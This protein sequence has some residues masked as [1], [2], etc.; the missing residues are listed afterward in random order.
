M[1]RPRLVTVGEAMIRLSPP[2]GLRVRDS[3]SFDVHVGGA[4]INVAVAAAQLGVDAVWVSALPK[5]PL[6]ERIVDHARRFRV[7]PIIC[8]SD[9]RVGVYFVELGA[10]PRG[11]EVHYD[12]QN[13]AFCVSPT[14]HAVAEQVAKPVDAVLVSGISVALGELPQRSVNVLLDRSHGAVRY[15]EIN[16][17]AKLWSES[18]AREAIAE[19]LDH[20]DVLIASKYDLTGLLALDPDPV[21]A[22]QRARE[23][24]RIDRVVITER[25]GGVGERGTN[26]VIVVDDD[27][28][29]VAQAEGMVI[30]PVGAGDAAT[31]A[32]IGTLLTT[33][34]VQ[35]AAE[36]SVRA[37]AMKQTVRGDAVALEVASIR[38][39]G[40]RI[41]R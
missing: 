9:A 11:S 40:P 8:P 2:S 36:A 29:A 7:E 13:S 41:R 14:E 16:H 23:R 37:A 38:G 26:A 35:Q 20:V 6:A 5:S 3:V 12:R 39:D 15:F 25:T 18:E 19:V 30:D 33:G 10:A 1:T 22:A 17:R 24:W 31:G 32:L 4:E 28:E 27:V 34:S 21:V